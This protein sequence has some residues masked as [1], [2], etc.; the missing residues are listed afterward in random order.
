V[1]GNGNETHSAHVSGSAGQATVSI[2]LA[3]HHGEQEDYLWG[4]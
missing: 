4:V 1:G 2:P 3:D